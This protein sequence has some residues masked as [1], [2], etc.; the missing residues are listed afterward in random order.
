VKHRTWGCLNMLLVLAGI[1]LFF[2][3]MESCRRQLRKP[4]HADKATPADILS[5]RR[6]TVCDPELPGRVYR[7]ERLGLLHDCLA[8]EGTVRSVRWEPDGDLTFKLDVD[9][10]YLKQY[11]NL[12][13][14]RNNGF[15]MVEIICA[16]TPT[17]PHA[18]DGCK[19]W[20][21]PDVPRLHKGDR[22]KVVG[23]HVIDTFH[24]HNEIHPAEVQV[25]MHRNHS[26]DAPEENDPEDEEK[27]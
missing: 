11:P 22:V 10:M 6:V 12:L 17:S 2:V 15:L 1:V 14:R 8:V 19:G 18:H 9:S 25:T 5:G 21:N 27:D 26:A 13:V 23:P 4:V 20:V 24:R 3:G 7:P 16:R